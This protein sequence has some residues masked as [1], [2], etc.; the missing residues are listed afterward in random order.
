MQLSAYLED[1]SLPVKE[2]C[3]L[4]VNSLKHRC[5]QQEDEQQKD[6]K[7][8]FNTVDPS[9]PFDGCSGADVPRLFNLLID[10]K[11]PLWTR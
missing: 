10:P 7:S 4:A 6:R 1:P 8:C 9:K 2:T 3:Q 5:Q 11:E